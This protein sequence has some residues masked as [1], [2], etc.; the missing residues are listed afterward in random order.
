MDFLPSFQPCQKVPFAVGGKLNIATVTWRAEKRLVF[1]SGNQQLCGSFKLITAKDIHKLIDCKANPNKHARNESTLATSSTST[2]T[3]STSVR[4]ENKSSLV[5]PGT[6][7]HDKGL[8]NYS[9]NDSS[10][11]EH[12]VRR[13]L[14]KPK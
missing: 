4:N 13:S 8:L 1:C 7:S 14:D 2:S 10:E 5:V 3:S 6:Q 11:N 9:G 12:R